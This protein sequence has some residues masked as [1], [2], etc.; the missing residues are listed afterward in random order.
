MSRSRTAFPARD[1][2]NWES[3]SRLNSEVI[4]G[5][6]ERENGWEFLN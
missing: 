2:E 5:H 1:W 3:S 6:R 4:K